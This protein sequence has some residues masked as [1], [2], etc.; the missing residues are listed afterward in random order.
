M[1]LLGNIFKKEKYKGYFEIQISAIE[2]LNETAVKVEFLIPDKLSS[3]FKF[4]PGQYINMLKE[5]DGKE[6]RRSY[7]ICS[8]LSEQLAIGVKR[9]EQGV[10]SNWFVKN[11]K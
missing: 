7:S 6:E 11:A 3:N 5:I 8:G 4:I 2:R 10:V 1:G 9:V